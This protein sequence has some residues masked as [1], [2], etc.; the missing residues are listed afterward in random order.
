MVCGMMVITMQG[1]FSE[2]WK[3]RALPSRKRAART[4]ADPCNSRADAASELP[5][6]VV[7]FSLVERV[8]V[9]AADANHE[10]WP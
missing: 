7:L 4:E 2:H 3:G 1:Q 8:T 6:E 5:R 10:R 9:R